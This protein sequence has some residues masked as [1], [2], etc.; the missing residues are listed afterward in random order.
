M[1][2]K[3]PFLVLLLSIS[4]V[5]T[6]EPD[7]NTGL[8]NA[9]SKLISVSNQAFV[10]E[11]V[12]LYKALLGFNRR[13]EAMANDSQPGDADSGLLKQNTLSLSERLQ[14]FAKNNPKY[15][16]LYKHRLVDLK[17]MPLRQ[18]VKKDF[19]KRLYTKTSRKVYSRTS[20]ERLLAASMD[21]QT[22]CHKS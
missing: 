3:K 16:N 19:K 6:A 11:S 14:K 18:S 5:L 10:N 9:V 2:H 21:C 7:F 12:A 8:G 20:L 4:F 15:D 1:L 13:I 22:R 17:V